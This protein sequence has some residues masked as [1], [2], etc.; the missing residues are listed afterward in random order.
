MV[1]KVC[2]S[3]KYTCVHT[4]QKEI[5]NHKMNQNGNCAYKHDNNGAQKLMQ[6]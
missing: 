6:M 4:Q 5:G 3:A 1:S 2:D